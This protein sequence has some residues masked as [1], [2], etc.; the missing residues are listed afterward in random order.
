M[1]N[2]ILAT[3]MGIHVLFLLTGC[4]SLG[5]S[6]IVRNLMDMDPNDGEEATRNLLYKEF[7]LTAGIANGALI[8]IA[9]VASLPGLLM[10]LRGWLKASGYMIT[11]CGVFTLCVG[12]YLWV[13][14][15]NIRESFFDTYLDQEP[16]VHDLIQTKFECC[17]YL[18]STAPAFVTNPTCPSPAAA[19]LLRGCATSISSFANN[20]LD[21][22]F[23][24][25][26]GFVGVDAIL[27]LSI[28][29]LAKD[30]KERERYRHIDEK[31]GYRQI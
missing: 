3:T 9:F 19:A 31:S 18:N 2:R 15:L 26:F 16:A 4:L 20:F 21:V 29:C 13:L 14:T 11:I 28:A 1:V 30:R 25:V 5:F 10:P 24:A 7:P 8:I 12:V 22:I 17:G 27:I 6:L 23:T